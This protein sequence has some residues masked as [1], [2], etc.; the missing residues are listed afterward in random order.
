MS[1]FEIIGVVLKI[2]PVMITGLQEV[3]GRTS[4]I[5][6]QYQ[7]VIT[8][9]IRYLD[10]EHAQLRTTLE[11]MLSG[12]VNE[13]ELAQLLEDQQHPI[14]KDTNLENR[15]KQRLGPEAYRIYISTMSRV[16]SALVG[17]REDVGFNQGKVSNDVCHDAEV[18]LTFSS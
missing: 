18:I 11:K 7:H 10:M 4:R 14:W 15:M 8:S 16:A 6:F 2:L 1:G 9:F 3:D 5:L 13:I 12:L 17:L